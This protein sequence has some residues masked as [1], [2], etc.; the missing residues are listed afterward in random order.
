MVAG[1]GVVF[2]LRSQPSTPPPKTFDTYGN[3]GRY[4]LIV[5]DSREY[6]IDTQTGRVWHS[7]V[8]MENKMIVFV[9]YT[10]QNIDGER[11]TLPNETATSVVVKRKPS[12]TTE[13]NSDK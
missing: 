3:D 12:S 1:A 7:V 11:S 2:A 6:V 8:D 10:Y 5:A 13:S 4:R 9:S